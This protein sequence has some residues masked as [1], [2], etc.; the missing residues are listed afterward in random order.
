[1]TNKDGQAN[2]IKLR[3][4]WYGDMINNNIS[5]KFEIKKKLGYLGIKQISDSVIIEINQRRLDLVKLKKE[6][7][8]IMINNKDLISYYFPTLM[9]SYKR[10]YFISKCNKIRL[11]ID[12][13][14]KFF[15]ITPY[16][17]IY[18]KEAIVDDIVVEIKFGRNT[19]E[20]DVDFITQ[21]IPFRLTKSSKYVKGVDLLLF[22]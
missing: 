13:N 18:K 20:S 4:R 14:Q 10:E 21:N 16:G 19:P 22:N 2:R 12:Y 8:N 3:F 7:K 17:T 1:M 11:T 5:G 9:N 6:F 15:R